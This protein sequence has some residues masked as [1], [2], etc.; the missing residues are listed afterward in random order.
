MTINFNRKATYALKKAIKPLGQNGPINWDE[1]AAKCG[2]TMKA[3]GEWPNATN[4]ICGQFAC[5]ECADPECQ[6]DHGGH[7]ELPREFT[8]NL[9]ATLRKGV[10]G[11]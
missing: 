6:A 8:T 2:T 9:V 5:G 1:L 7:D 10:D 11:Q 4:G 3:L